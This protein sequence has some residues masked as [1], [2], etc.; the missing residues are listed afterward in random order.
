MLLKWVGGGL[1]LCCGGIWVR[2]QNRTECEELARIA[3]FG[4]LLQH[5]GEQIDA[6]CLPL[7]EI[8]TRTSPTLLR[9]CGI[10]EEGL[11]SA[12]VQAGH[13]VR[14]PAAEVLDRV[15]ARLGQGTREDQIRLCRSAAQSLMECRDRLS[16]HISRNGR[17]RRTLWLT[18]SLC[19]II[20]LW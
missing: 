7:D 4:E 9:A 16:D 14:G 2:M 10:R 3:A 5:I 1:L 19:G 13:S 11:L 12:L 18:M 15:A 8:L 6:F 20:L 17:V